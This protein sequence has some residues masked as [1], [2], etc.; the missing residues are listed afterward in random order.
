VV[1]LKAQF[2]QRRLDA[3]EAAPQVFGCGK[4][5][6]KDEV[7]VVV[8]LSLKFEPFVGPSG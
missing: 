8:F 7:R 3:R 4:G 5:E 6:A 2:E 1:G